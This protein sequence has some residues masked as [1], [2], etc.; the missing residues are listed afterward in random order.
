MSGTVYI[1]GASG[2]IGRSAAVKF[3]SEGFNT[4]ICCDKNSD[5][6]AGTAALVRKTGKKCFA[7]TGDISDPKVNSSF[8]GK[9]VEAAGAPD[10]LINNAGI[11]IT[12]LFQD[13][14]PEEWEH[15]W[16]SNVSTAFFSSQNAV[17]SMLGK[18]AGKIINVSS[19][20]GDC[21]AS[22]ETAY[23][24]TKGAV[25]AMTM[26]LAKELAP[27]GI[28]VNA[29]SFGMI[30]TRMNSFLSEE[31]TLS[32]RDEIPAG[33]I[34]SADEAAEFLYRIYEMPPY[35]TGQVIRFDGGWI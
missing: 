4:A 24:A 30:D 32:I 33:R 17:R 14:T 27:S 19:I 6:L 28:Q 21:G 3:A 29:A 8:F 25:R 34:A 1:T 35:M 9:A 31:E 16:N 23:S 18:K 22:C 15:I 26:A 7:F 5:G 12:G 13:M 20:W 11:S 2:G 10:V